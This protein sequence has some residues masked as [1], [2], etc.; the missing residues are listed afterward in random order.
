MWLAQTI[1]ALVAVIGA[2]LVR[3]TADPRSRRL[4]GIG[5]A[6]A[7]GTAD[8]VFALSGRIR[9]VYLVDALIE[10]TLVL[11]W[12]IA[13]REDRTVQDKETSTPR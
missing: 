6:G 2:V 11:A 8:L 7:L 9:R 13:S 1:G 12:V 3:P 10:T 5:S 4:L